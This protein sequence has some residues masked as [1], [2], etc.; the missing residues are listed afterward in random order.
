MQRI[1]RRSAPR[2]RRGS[3]LVLVLI[4]TVA[5]SALAASAILLTSGTTLLGKYFHRERE[6]KYS[7]EAALAIAKSRLNN[8]PEA[9]PDSSYVVLMSNAPVNGADGTPITGVRVNLYAGPTGSTSGQFG[10]FASVV[11]DARDAAGSRFVRR[12]ELAQESFAK[13]AYWS[14]RE[15]NNGNTIYFGGGDALFGPVWSN[16]DI[17]IASSGAKFFDEV[18]TAG[19]IEGVGYGTY[20]KGYSENLRPITLPTITALSKLAGY[21]GAGSLAFNAPNSNDE[22]GVRMRIQ[23]VAA[24]LNAL[25]DSTD[26]NEGF[27]RVYVGNSAA[28]V[29]GD[30]NSENCGDWHRDAP[31]GPFKFYPAAVHNSANAWFVNSIDANDGYSASGADAHAGAS[32]NTIMQR[33]NARCFP[34]G[35]PHLAAVERRGAAGYPANGW[36]LGGTPTT[37]TPAGVKGQWLQWPGAVDPIVSNARPLE[38][39][40]LFPLFRG[41]NPGVKGVITVNGTAAVSGV[42]RGRVTLYATGTVVFVDDLRYATDPASGRCRDILGIIAAR[43]AVVADNAINTPVSNN[44]WRSYDDNRDMHLH[45]VIMALSTSFRVE[46]YNAGP[47]NA[48]ACG[49]TPWGRGCLHLTGGLIQEAR[50]AVGTLSGTGFLKRYSYDRCVLS[51]PPPYFP[52]T[53]RF[54]DNRYYEIDPVRFDVDQ[55]Y[56]SLV[57][58]Y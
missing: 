23:F 56:R 2:R 30:Y 39:P 38:A 28:W 19:T 43:D 20:A 16:D 53:G 34:G 12:L 44:G 52:T 54:I 9:L 50:G 31:G 15:S 41:L 7:A 13:F 3:A 42:L 37:F 51:T 25:N 47:T 48:S 33:P 26:A 58:N 4:M 55:L 8:D 22:T 27:V 24:D 6:F 29:R 46:D 21:A 57:P 18:G 11:A 32:F 14:N 10:R 35:D 49:T 5:L 1:P 36:H 17:H 40:Y 45:S